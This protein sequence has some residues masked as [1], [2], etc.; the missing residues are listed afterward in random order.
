MNKKIKFISIGILSILVI[1][2]SLLINKKEVIQASA[3]GLSTSKIEWG[4]KRNNNHEQP[5]VG[6]ENKQILE[7]NNG[8]YLGNKDKK[9][10]YLTFDEGYEAR[11][12]Y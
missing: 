3:K 4:I 6:T 12:Y 11:L 8:I 2:L 9:Y 7:E 5:E 10:I 1:F